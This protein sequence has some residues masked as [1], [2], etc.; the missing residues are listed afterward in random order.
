MDRLPV[1]MGMQ[2]ARSVPTSNLLGLL[3]VSAGSSVLCH[4]VQHPSSAVPFLV[5][6]KSDYNEYNGKEKK[7]SASFPGQ[8]SSGFGLIHHEKGLASY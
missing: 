6:Y 1:G 7:G 5:E 8:S 2:P 4:L 3:F